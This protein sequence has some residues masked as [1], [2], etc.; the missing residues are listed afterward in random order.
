M[1]EAPERIR[2]VVTEAEVI[3]SFPED[4]MRAQDYIRADRIEALEDH[5]QNMI[6]LSGQECACGYDNPDDVCLG[7][8][9]LLNKVAALE[10]ENARL[11]EA[12]S[13]VAYRSAAP[14]DLPWCRRIARAALAEGGDT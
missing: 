5:I 2:V 12:L 13:A 7:H 10:A 14:D 1:T 9:S 8:A 6:D 3:G 4:D 11:R